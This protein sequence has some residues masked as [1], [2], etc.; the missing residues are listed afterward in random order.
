MN[1]LTDIP[2]VS[3]RLLLVAVLSL[4]IT[5][6]LF[7]LSRFPLSW[8]C[9]QCGIIGGIVSIQQ[10]LKTLSD[11][12][13]QLLST[14]WIELIF[15]PVFGGIFAL[16]IY[17]FFIARVIDGPLFPQIVAPDFHNPPHPDDL[18]R[19]FRKTTPK[20]G[21]DFAK[22]AIWAF[23]AGFSE[24]LVPDIIKRQLKNTS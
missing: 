1:P 9:F 4:T 24:R 10:R 20:S 6:S 23:A 3:R 21:A 5:A 14:S 8:F 18:A 22:L 7:L 16:V 15:T 17:L 19:F 12:E 13:I 2:L 11:E